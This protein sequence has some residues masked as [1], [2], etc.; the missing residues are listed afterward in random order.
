MENRAGVFEDQTNACSVEYSQF[1]CHSALFIVFLGEGT[2][3][4]S[5]PAPAEAIEPHDEQDS[6]D[7]DV[8]M[9]VAHPLPDVGVGGANIVE[10]FD[11]VGGMGAPPRLAGQQGHHV[12]GEGVKLGTPV[13]NPHAI[14]PAFRAQ[15][16]LESAVKRMDIQNQALQAAGEFSIQFGYKYIYLQHLLSMV[17]RGSTGNRTCGPF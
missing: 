7:D 4:S 16:A 17:L 6:P 10:V 11:A 2:T 9:P 3:S 8:E 14:K 15:S 12:W 13:D 1:L 5:F